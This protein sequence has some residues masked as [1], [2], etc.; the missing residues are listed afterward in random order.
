MEYACQ[1]S[2]INDVTLSYRRERFARINEINREMI[3]RYDQEERL[4]VRY[5][6][7]IDSI[8]NEEERSGSTTTTAFRRSMTE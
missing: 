1:L 2:T 3:E 7:D 4:R 8:E 6:I 5:G